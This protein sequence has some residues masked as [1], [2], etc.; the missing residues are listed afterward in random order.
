MGFGLSSAIAAAEISGKPV[1]CITGDAG[2][3]MA[4][5]ELGLLAE[6]QLPVLIALMNDAALDLIR[7]AQVRRGRPV[8]RH[9]I[10]QPGLPIHCESLRNRVSQSRVSGGVRRGHPRGTSRQSATADRCDD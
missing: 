6:R 10:C 9:R 4:L 2:L 3:A 1:V 7:S 8:F 5:G